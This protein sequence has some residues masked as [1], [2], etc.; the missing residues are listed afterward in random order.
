M[1]KMIYLLIIVF[2]LACIET[3]NAKTPKMLN[4]SML[5]VKNSI[6]SINGNEVLTDDFLADDNWWKSVEKD[7]SEYYGKNLK[8]KIKRNGIASDNAKK[9]RKLY[10]NYGEEDVSFTN[11]IGGISSNRATLGI[12][13][14]KELETNHMIFNSAKNIN[15]TFGISRY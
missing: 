2:T 13:T 3:I 14:F 1:K 10:Q 6:V 15:S 5:F 11:Y 8:E 4:T 9:I 12:G 7:Y